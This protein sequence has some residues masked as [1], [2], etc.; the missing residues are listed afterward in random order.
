[1]GV[2]H[3]APRAMDI[4]ERLVNQV[5]I[6]IV[7]LQ[8]LQRLIDGLLCSIETGVLHPELG[9][10]EELITRNAAILEAL[11]YCAFV[12]IRCC[13]VNLSIA[14]LDR[15]DDAALAFLWIGNLKDAK[16]EDRHFVSGVQGYVSHD[17]CPHQVPATLAV[18]YQQTRVFL[19]YNV[20]PKNSVNL[21]MA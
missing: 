9:R 8:P 6:Q 16:T 19:T 3:G 15:I 5:Q 1:M 17:Q 21:P 18:L 14:G 2:L 20:F 12:H 4:P 11:S 10:N 7:Q 13:R